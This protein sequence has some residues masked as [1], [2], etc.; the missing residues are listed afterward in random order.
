MARVEY[1]LDEKVAIL[2]M[3]DGE[4]RRKGILLYDDETFQTNPPLSNAYNRCNIRSC[5]CWRSHHE[6]CL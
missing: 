6:L 2:T 1:T 3:N 5:V 4:N